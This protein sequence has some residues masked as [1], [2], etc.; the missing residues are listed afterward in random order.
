MNETQ[1]KRILTP[2]EVLTRHKLAAKAASDAVKGFEELETL[3]DPIKI[4]RQL[5]AIQGL[6]TRSLRNIEDLLWTEKD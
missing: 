3:T 2:S 1:T 5:V 4:R 6:L